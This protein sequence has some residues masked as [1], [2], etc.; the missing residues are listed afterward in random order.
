MKLCKPLLALSLL[1]SVNASEQLP[2]GMRTPNRPTK[3]TVPAGP[4]KYRAPLARLHEAPLQGDE[5]KI[6]FETARVAI[7][8][9]SESS[10]EELNKAFKACELSLLSE[11]K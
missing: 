3:L 1:A 2:E 9:K 6:L 5:F 10:I 4:A 8:T 7:M 11:K